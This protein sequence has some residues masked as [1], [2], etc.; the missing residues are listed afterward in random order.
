MATAPAQS[1][2]TRPRTTKRTNDFSI[3]VATVNGSG[4]QTANNAIFRALFRMG[5]PV[6]GKNLFPSNIKGQPTWYTIRVS[7]DGYAARTDKAEVLIAM[8]PV[9][10]ARDLDDLCP[11]GVCLHPDHV[12][13]PTG[14]DDVRF[15]AMP[16]KGI[17]KDLQPDR[18]FREY[19]ENMVYV[20]V[21]AR[22][23]GIE[24]DE[25]RAALDFH[26]SGKPGPVAMNFDVIQRGFD[27]AGAQENAPSPFRVERMD[28]TR[29]HLLIDGN[30]A[31]A[32]GAVFGGVGFLGWYPITPATSLAEALIDYL[33]DL[34]VEPE[35]GKHTYAV[36]QSEDELA[37]IGMLLG[38]GWA[39]VRAMTATSGPGV[40]L[41][42]EFAGYAWYAEIPAVV[43][44]VQRSGPSTGLPTRTAQGDLLSTFVLG[45]GDGTHPILLPGSV[46]ECFDFGW[47]AFD[48]AERLQTLVFVLS[49]LDLGMNQWM[50]PEFRYP[51]RPLDRG[52]VL[53]AADLD[54]IGEWGR[55]A[56]VDGD[57]IPWRTVPGNPHRNAAYFTRG[58]GHDGAARYT[59]NSVTYSAMLDRL[60]RKHASA[61]L[62]MP[63]PVEER[64][65]G[66]SVGII[67]YGSTDPAVSEA[68][69][70]LAEAGLPTSYLRIRAVPPHASVAQFIEA[71]ERVFVVELNHDGQM[72]QLLTI[73]YPDLANRLRSL[74]HNNGL[75]L[76]A[77]W[78]VDAMRACEGGQQ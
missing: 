10:I 20:G 58:S 18:R 77:R 43:W 14:R 27:W 45:H 17:I 22:L 5:I 44:D 33:A 9:S 11:G 30:S 19:L 61:P 73:H 1:P 23:V 12:A 74:T 35:T 70:R 41:M 32:L 16:V 24:L 51:D 75:P 2:A 21:L 47:Q 15:V 7:K 54:Q 59:E 3:T 69:D 37:A 48:V 56:D 49:D 38:A 31:A 4:S 57:G 26:F 67:A 63:A 42:A 25:L 71:H 53:S 8:N 72:R 65:E 78:L 34:R 55:Y 36:V 50:S 39:G 40:S 62:Y 13:A 76:T 28:A 52:K 29:G 68:R 64:V 46:A 60:R 6:A 66:A